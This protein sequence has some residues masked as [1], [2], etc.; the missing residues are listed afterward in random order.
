MPNLKLGIIG[1]CH[2]TDKRPIYRNDE[3]FYKTQFD[4]LNFVLTSL[5]ET[6]FDIFLGDMFDTV[7]PSRYLVNNII[8]ILQK[9]NKQ[10]LYVMGNHE[11]IGSINIKDYSDSAIF[12][13]YLAKVIEISENK[14][15]ENVMF[16]FIPEFEIENDKTW[17]FDEKFKSYKKVIIAHK[18]LTDKHVNFEHILINDIN[19]NADIVISGHYHY[20]F[21]KKIGKTIF[22]NPGSIIRSDINEKDKKCYI[23]NIEI[24]NDIKL[25]K[26]EIPLNNNAFNIE[27]Y[28]ETKKNQIELESFINSISNMKIEVSNPDIM[29]KELIKDADK[30]I[31]TMITK[32]FDKLKLEGLC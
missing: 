31:G 25:N 20:S 18:M 24:G 29:I 32:E 30:N 19:T 27:K 22:L 23:Y 10:R 13:S 21:E 17:I 11:K 4:K 26:I 2:F 6:K 15:I 16:K 9:F 14:E 12:S 28:E 7:N 3:D 8:S 5:A 1:D